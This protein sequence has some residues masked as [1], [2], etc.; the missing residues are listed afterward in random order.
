[1]FP[2]RRGIVAI[3][4]IGI[5]VGGALAPPGAALSSDD[6][7]QVSYPAKLKVLRAAVRN[8]RLEAL[9]SITGR[10]TGTITVDYQAAGQFRRMFVAIGPPQEGEKRVAVSQPLV[11]RQR[12]LTT[13]I[14]NASFAGDDAAQPDSTRLRAAKRRSGLT[15]EQ[16][17]FANG[18]LSVGGSIDRRVSGVVHL[19]ASYLDIDGSSGLWT[20]R[21]AGV[22]GAWKLD[23]R[24]PAAATFDPNAYL[25]MQF[26]GQKDARGGAFGGKQLGKSLGN[27]DGNPLTL[28]ADVDQQAPGDVGPCGDA[29]EGRCPG[30]DEQ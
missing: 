21:A 20:G 11:G 18:R 9:L 13:G 28:P 30:G 22:K 1:M 8:G 26:T 6:A 7:E 10:A 16:L 12:A 17:T 23:E 25:T 5:A 29:D 3:T 4:A 19:R 24:L 27:L 2:A 15:L 14:I